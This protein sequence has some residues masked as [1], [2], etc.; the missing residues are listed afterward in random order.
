MLIPAWECFGHQGR[1]WGQGDFCWGQHPHGHWASGPFSFLSSCPSGFIGQRGSGSWLRSLWPMGIALWWA[2]IWLSA[3][4][5]FFRFPY[6]TRDFYF[7]A[8]LR[9]SESWSSQTKRALLCIFWKGPKSAFC[10][11]RGRATVGRTLIHS[12]RSTWE[13]EAWGGTWPFTPSELGSRYSIKAH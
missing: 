2:V 10:L 5:F 11:Q 13:Q 12:G 9:L 1:K 7:H 4:F 8:R 6:N 3:A